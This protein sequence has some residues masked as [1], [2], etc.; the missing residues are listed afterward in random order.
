VREEAEALNQPLL[1]AIARG[2]AEGEMRPLAVEGLPAALAGLKR[3][4]DGVGLV[5]RVYEPASARGPVRLALPDG[6]RIAGPVDILERPFDA[7]DELRPFEVKSWRLA[8]A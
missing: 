6:W 5:L 1:A 2:V 3:A 4:E 7:P 8:P